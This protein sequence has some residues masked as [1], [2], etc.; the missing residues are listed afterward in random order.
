ML[1]IIYIDISC[2]KW[3]K[4]I[5]NHFKSFFVHALALMWDQ[6]FNEGVDGMFEPVN[7]GSATFFWKELVSYI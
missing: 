4:A 5:S 2:N 6:G 7:Q 1:D 3:D